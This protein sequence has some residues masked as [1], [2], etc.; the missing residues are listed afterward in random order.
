MEKNYKHIVDF[1][2]DIEV[3]RKKYK[4]CKISIEFV[5]YED[6]TEVIDGIE[7]HKMKKKIVGYDDKLTS[8]FELAAYY[9][10]PVLFYRRDFSTRYRFGRYL[11]Y[12][13]Y[14]FVVL[15]SI[16]NPDDLLNKHLDD[17]EIGEE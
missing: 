9:D 3:D 11:G 7:H 1:V 13:F 4:V 16:F 14:Y 2:K 12:V 6:S 15:G 10:Y 17:Q 5:V 8:K